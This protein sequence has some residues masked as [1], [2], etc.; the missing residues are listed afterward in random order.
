MMQTVIFSI[1]LPRLLVVSLCGATLSTAGV[2]SQGL[3]RNPLASPSVLGASSG[4]VLGAVIV[5]YFVS[6]WHHWFLLPAGAFLATLATM[7]CILFLFRSFCEADSSQ[8]LICGFVIT[9]LLGA[10][11]SLLISLML[12]QIER[13][14][15]L[16][17]WMMGGF[18]GRSWDHFIFALPSAVLGLVLASTLVR[19]LDVLCLGE[20]LASSLNINVRTLQRTSVLAIAFLVGSSVSVAGALPFVGLII[21]HIT[22]QFTGPMH[23]YLLPSSIFNGMILLILADMFA[24]KVFYPREFEVGTL[25]SLLGVVFFFTILFRSRHAR[26]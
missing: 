18:N 2:I 6:P 25:T 26:T 16:M 24:Q 10:I 12:P 5:Y 8:L 15:S 11:S 4:G 23:R 1:R 7:A 14:S 3:F 20:E 9:T 19:K 13:A 21:P 17:Q 22:R